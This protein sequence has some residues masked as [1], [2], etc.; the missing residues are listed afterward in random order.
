MA[1]D[2][3][4][5]P[6]VW[7]AE[8]LARAHG[9]LIASGDPRLDA[10][11]GGGWPTPALI[12]LLVDHYGIGELTLLL[13]LLRS[14][15]DIRPGTM[16]VWLNPPHALHAVALLQRELDPARQWI[17][18]DLSERDAAWAF[19]TSLRSGACSVV[20]GWLQRPAAAVL[21]RLKLA[22]STGYTTGVLFRPG[23]AAGT[24]SPATV[25]L[26]LT[27]QPPYLQVHLLKIQG[28]RQANLCLD[29]RSRI[30][31]GRSP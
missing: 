26:Q 18:S 1:I 8:S 9:E 7:P 4:Q 2:L 12:E 16:A 28:R 19:E 13:P 11:L 3:Q 30:E 25:R 24:P 21:R 15:S 10:A 5:L 27:P 17:A 14:L 22:T 20:L 6:N 31:Q 23:S 29:L